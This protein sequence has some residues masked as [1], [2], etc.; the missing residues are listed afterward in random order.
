MSP[1][2]E[3]ACRLDPFNAINDM[4]QPSPFSPSDTFVRRH[5]S[6]TENDI[7]SMIET[8][9]VSSLDELINQTIPADIRLKGELNLGRERGEQGLLDELRGVAEKNEVMT[10]HIG[11]GYHS[12]ITP[13]VI[14]RNVLE[15][16]AWYTQYTPYQAE[17]SQGRLEALLIFQTAQLP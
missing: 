15:N 11:M 14:L 6:P 5:I 4:T 10:S 16:P 12:C 8:V 3:N 9:G 17:I 1:E 7:A 13:P 2:G